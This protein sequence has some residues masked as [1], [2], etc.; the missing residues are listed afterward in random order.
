M[1]WNR[2]V[3]K[4]QFVFV[5]LVV[6]LW[7]G[8]C[9]TTPPSQK[10]NAPAAT[11]QVLEL[12]RVTHDPVAE[13]YPAPSLDGKEILIHVRDDTK[14]GKERWSIAAI[15]IGTPGRR[16]IA[17]YADSPA[18][19]KD[20]SGY[21]FCYQKG[22]KA[23]LAKSRINATGITFVSPSALGEWDTSPDVSPDGQ[24]I[25]FETRIGN[26]KNICSVNMDGSEFT[27]FTPGYGPKW[28]PDGN[29]ILFYKKVGEHNHLFILDLQ[30]GQITQLT[31]GES[32]NFDGT[33][34][35][36]D[37]IVFISDR[38]DND[39]VYMMKAD[40]T[41]ISQLTTGNTDETQPAWSSEGF[42]YFSSNAGAEA[43]VSKW[44]HAD[45]WK[46]KPKV[47]FSIE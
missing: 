12:T 3:F 9:A 17:T 10:A 23:V 41:E 46:L 44:H 32:N 18:W 30:S 29:L 7:L 25:I 35:S 15:K 11:G 43:G 8:G 28:H 24:K 5:S 45:I 36:R 33:W 38:D 40:G 42:I 21:I 4:G 26:E 39:H 16:L 19:L 20:G 2:H 47:S 1:R 34:C 37:Y 27:V 6:G 31:S 13:F 14:K 22:S